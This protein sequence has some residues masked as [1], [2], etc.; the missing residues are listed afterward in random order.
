MTPSPRI[1]AHVHLPA[2]TDASR[3]L[4]EEAQVKV[5][6]ICAA[7]SRIGGCDA[8]RAWYRPLAA[9]HPDRFAWVTSFNVEHFAAPDWAERAIAQLAGDFAGDGAAVGCKVWKNIGMELRDP[10][11]G[12]WVFVDDPRFDPI[13]RWLEKEGRPLLMHIGEPLACWQP[14]DP[15]SPHYAYYSTETQWH[16][17]GRDDVPT[18]QRLMESR[19]AIVQ[20]YP[21]LTVIGA[22]YGSLEFDLGE[23]A[24][25]FERY[26]NFFVDTSARLVDMG[27][28]AAAD[29]EAVRDFFIRWSDRILWG[30]DTVCDR[31]ISAMDD[32]Q[33]EAH[34][35]QVQRLLRKEWR[36]F[37]TADDLNFNGRTARGLA[38]PDDVLQR[39]F[40]DNARRVYAGV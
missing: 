12:D 14:L 2:D 9:R 36:F 39:L 11:T 27:L 21:K 28:H 7:S 34:L 6:N 33:R 17:H 8:Q 25:R 35:G 37:A 30:T 16:W 5:I 24:A 29:R 32:T 10:A 4:L 13:F 18:H 40:L 26:P 23:M 20:R 19:D 22:H 3:A 1:D 31:P 38:L 15:A